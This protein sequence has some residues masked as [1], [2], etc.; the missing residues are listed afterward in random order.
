MPIENQLPIL[1]K[2][3]T[4]RILFLKRSDVQHQ[5]LVI[6]ICVLVSWLLSKWFWYWLQK[7]FP[8]ATTFIWSDARLPPRQ[9]LAMLIQKLDFPLISFIA[10]NL[11]QIFF[12]A[13]DWTRGLLATAIKLMWVYLLYRLFLS[14]L[15]AAF[16][17]DIV[18]QYHYRLL[19]P[20]GFLFLL[21]T[22][23]NLTNNLVQLSEFSPFQLFNTPITLGAIFIL[24]AGLYFWI[25]T[26]ILVEKLLLNFLCAGSQ[27]DSGA[28]E[29]SLILIRYFLIAF[30]IVVILGYVRFNVTALAAI[31]GGL[32]VGIGFGLQ[33]VVS[34]FVSGFILLFERVLKPG[35]I[36]SVDGQTS[37]VKKLGVRAI[38]VLILKDNSEKIIPNQTFFTSNVTTYTGSD[39]LINC[40]ITVGVGYDSKAKQVMDLLLQIADEHPSVLKEPTPSAFLTDFGDSSLNFE[41]K[42]W[43]ND[44]NFKKRVMSD[45]SCLILDKFSE[46]KIEIP[47]PQRD[48]H[49][50][51]EYLC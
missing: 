30:G 38:T 21:G 43:L 41:L 47:F 26:V 1:S 40:S 24:I 31:T 42:F 9:Y 34:N 15:Y 18:R 33:Q 13:Q 51:S 45:L 10:L 35:D 36:I 50:R 46:H 32:S 37:Q 20:L 22:I 2:F 28:L 19:A 3:I 16:P 23:V 5:L 27:L 11:I 44:I 14:S 17:I 6:T 8:Q 29:A 39:R 48:I 7:T 12:T 4:T 25:V 49:I